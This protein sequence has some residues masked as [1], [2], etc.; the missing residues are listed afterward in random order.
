MSGGNPVE[1]R[2]LESAA[3][4]GRETNAIASSE[5]ANIV[6]LK[7]EARSKEVPAWE[8]V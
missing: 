5:R 6:L 3:T 8:I 2:V 4:P 7:Y 1:F